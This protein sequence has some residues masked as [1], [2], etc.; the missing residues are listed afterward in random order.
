[1]PTEQVDILS[2]NTDIAQIG[3]L[4][5]AEKASLSGAFE[6]TKHSVLTL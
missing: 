2:W 3:V 4:Y 6:L 5:V 1:M